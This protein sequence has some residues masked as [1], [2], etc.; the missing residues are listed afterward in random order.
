VTVFKAPP[1]YVF[2]LHVLPTLWLFGG[3]FFAGRLLYFRDLSGS[4]APDYEF[5]SRSLGLGVW[6]L[7]NPYVD[8]G[9]PCLFTYPV[10]LVLVGLFG[11]RSPLGLGAALHVYLAMCGASVLAGRLGHRTLGAWL[12]GVVYGLSG[13]LLSSVNLLQLLSAAAWAPWVL[14]ALLALLEKPSARRAAA[15]AT[16]A[17]IQAS[18]LGG[19]IAVQ[20]AL[21]VPFLVPGW[22]RFGAGALA[23]LAQATLAAVLLA[24][25]VIAGVLWLLRGTTRGHGFSAGEAL[26]YS[27]H[28]VVLFDSVLPRFFGDVH[29]F[30]EVG[31]W[32]QPFFPQGYPYLLSLYVGPLVLLLA[33]AARP[34]RLHLLLVFGVVASLGS[35]GPLGPVL[36]TVLPFLRAPVKYFFL[37]TLAA[38]LLASAGLERLAVARVRR[39]MVVAMLVGGLVLVGLAAVV[40]RRPDLAAV[41]FDGFIPELMGARALFVARTSWSVDWLATGG[42]CLAAGLLMLRSARWSSFL[43]LMVAVDLLTVNGALN[44]LAP[45]SFYT[46]R[47]AM[48]EAVREAEREGRFRWFSYGTANSPGVRW[49]P[50]F[51]RKGSDV[52]LYYVDRQALLPRTQA[53]EALEGVFDVNRAGWA[54]PGSTL[55]I[56]EMSPAFFARHVGRMRLANVRWVISFDRLSEDAVRLRREVPVP[57]LLGPLLL[58]ELRDPLPRAFLADAW[59]V[60]ENLVRPSP[61]ARVEYS[62]QGPHKVELKVGSPPGTVVVL[63]PSHPSWRLV[64][65]DGKERVVRAFGRYIAFST[66]GGDQVFTLRLEPGWRFPAL[67]LAGLGALICLILATGRT[68]GLSRLDT[69]EPAR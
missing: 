59:P 27:A 51:A 19:D 68:E 39:A 43:G 46:L 55:E 62:R 49:N 47:P 67:L 28:P 63:D 64:G 22:R 31:Y 57:E 14:A 50:T 17:A 34:S 16:L 26:S 9:S 10:D 41:F 30:S 33:L 52:W 42:L 3:V 40:R 54:P 32:G 18:T 25:P 61:Q 11:P 2:L 1:R 29:A 35:Y 58:Y 65:P 5:L 69:I 45:A 38:A 66:P 44:P 6:P 53:F 21:A 12:A 36:S 56:A 37:T 13:F 8:G 60:A 20:T 15:L 23:R 4:Y 24:A 48:A 7:W